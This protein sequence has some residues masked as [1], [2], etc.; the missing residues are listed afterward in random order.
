MNAKSSI[1]SARHLARALFF[2][3]ARGRAKT[4]WRE[5]A[6][7]HGIILRRS[8]SFA[9]VKE[10]EAK[11]D[12]TQWAVKIIAKEKM[13]KEDRDALATGAQGQPE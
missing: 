1:S 10:A 7:T 9:T 8:G 12:S 4:L 5:R 11:E 13:D 2:A 6:L 3:G